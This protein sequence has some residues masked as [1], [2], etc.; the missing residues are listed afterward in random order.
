MEDFNYVHSNCFEITMELSC[1]KYPHASLLAG[2]WKLNKEAMLSYMEA[3]HLGIR[4]LV[5]DAST[6]KGIHQAELEVEGIN[7]NVITTERGEFWRLLVGGA[8]AHY[9]VR[10]HAYGY[11]SSQWQEVK[12]ADKG[13]LEMMVSRSD[14]ES[15]RA[16]HL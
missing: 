4:G 2:E 5:L 15:A 3:T 7:K 10:A 9:R 6:K 16:P 11:Q 1:C 8:G 14:G 12:V 13:N